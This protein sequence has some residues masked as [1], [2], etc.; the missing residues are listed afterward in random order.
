MTD[1][2][3]KKLRGV[4]NLEIDKKKGKLFVEAEENGG[5]EIDINQTEVMHL[6]DKY[7]DE[8]Y[9]PDKIYGVKRID[10]LDEDW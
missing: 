2:S 10:G 1:E 7:T 9:G 4:N 8:E 6:L 3:I 5:V